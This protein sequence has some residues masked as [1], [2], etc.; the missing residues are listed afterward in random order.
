MCDVSGASRLIGQCGQL[1]QTH[2][3][4]VPCPAAQSHVTTESTNQSDPFSALHLHD[5]FKHQSCSVFTA[6]KSRA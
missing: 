2:T 6:D 5:G 3:D 4:C 1:T